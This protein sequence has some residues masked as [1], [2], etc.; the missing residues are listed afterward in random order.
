LFIYK[1]TCSTCRKARGFL[2]EV[3]GADGFEERD[4]NL[5]PMTPEELDLLIGSHDYKLFLNTRNELYRERKMKER[6]PTRAD[7]LK[8]M[9]AHA[10]LIKR[11]LLVRRGNVVYGFDEDAFRALLGK[12]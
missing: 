1:K 8:L 2:T 9:A 7:A 12:D 3:A 10:N 6:P 11:P 4:L 5:R